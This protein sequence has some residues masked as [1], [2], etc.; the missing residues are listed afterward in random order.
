MTLS[1]GQMEY[2]GVRFICLNVGYVTFWLSEF[3]SVIQFNYLT[4]SSL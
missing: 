2:M 1:G 3:D 4:S